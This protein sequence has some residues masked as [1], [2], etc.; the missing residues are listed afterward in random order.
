MKGWNDMLP[1]SSLIAVFTFS[2]VVGLGAVISPG[3]VSTTI[4]SQAPWRGWKTGPLVATGHA[5]LELLLVALITVGLGVGLAHPS[6]QIVIAF[7]GGLLLA[8]MGGSMIWNTWLGKIHLPGK[9]EKLP[10]MTS[11]QLVGLGM[12]ATLSNPFWY[13][14]WVTVAAGYLAQAQTL[15]IAAVLAF[16]LGHIVADYAWDT[17]LSAVVGGGRRWMT[18]KAYRILIYACGAFFVYL[19]WVFLAQGISG[20]G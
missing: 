18:D 12:L 19:G 10:P 3:P 14:W 9:N 2:F 4:V 8:W 16:Y 15:S 6:V 13:A 11:W 7:L 5:L 17:V 1:T 20:L